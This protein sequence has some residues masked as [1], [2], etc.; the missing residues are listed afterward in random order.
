MAV[1]SIWVDYV[2]LSVGIVMVGLGALF[3]NKILTEIKP[4]EEPVDNLEV[5]LVKLLENATK[6][7]EEIFYEWSSWLSERGLDQHL[8]P[9]ATEK[10][11]D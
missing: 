9:L 3:R 6:K 11:D 2:I 10:L 8:S 7:R 5:S 1:G 4:E